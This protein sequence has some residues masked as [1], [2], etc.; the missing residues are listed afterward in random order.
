MAG[1]H[2]K[3]ELQEAKQKESEASIRA[4]A[5]EAEVEQ[6]RATKQE[7]QVLLE[8]TAQRLQVKGPHLALHHDDKYII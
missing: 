8:D 7:M 5:L 1:L 3:A 6:H 2:V 4:A